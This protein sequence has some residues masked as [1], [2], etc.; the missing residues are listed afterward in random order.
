MKNNTNLK[1]YA[2]NSYWHATAEKRATV[3]NGCGA[4]G[5]IKVPDSFFV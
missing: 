3:C 2:P 1:L 5:G 4:K